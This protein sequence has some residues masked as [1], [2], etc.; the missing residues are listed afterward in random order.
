MVWPK[1]GWI[2]GGGSIM[3]KTTIWL[4][5]TGP[6]IKESCKILGNKAAAKNDL[7]ADQNSVDTTKW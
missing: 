1:N 7:T 4:D 2:K 6:L 3:A 5:M